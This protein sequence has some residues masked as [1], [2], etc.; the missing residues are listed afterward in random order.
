MESKRDAFPRFYFLSDDEVLEILAKSD[1]TS[2]VQQ[3]LKTMF[4]GVVKVAIADN[5]EVT[6]MKSKEGEAV[7]LATKVKIKKE[8]DVWLMELQNQII[9]T[10]R[11]EMKKAVSDYGTQ[12]RKDWVMDPKHPG[13]TVAT[14]AQIMWCQNT[15]ANIADMADENPF[16]LQ[17]WWDQQVIQIEE[18]TVLVR[19][20]LS[21]L[22]RHVVVA[23]I[24]TDVHARDIV[25]DLKA[26][27]VASNFD[28]EW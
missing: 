4:D 9:A 27:N 3:Y 11:K 25:E 14:V 23:L 1:D 24:T 28:F 26:Q 13:Q 15:E 20:Q 19:G 7:Q 17:E 2:I 21:D 22:Q 10:L 6:H 12:A 18:L 8:V 5:I 16:A